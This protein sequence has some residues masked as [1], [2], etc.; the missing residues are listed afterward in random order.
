MAGSVQNAWRAQCPIGCGAL[1]S[2][3]DLLCLYVHLPFFVVFGSAYT[4]RPV[5]F[6]LRHF[7]LFLWLTG[8][9]WWACWPLSWGTTFRHWFA[10]DAL[11]VMHGY[12]CHSVLHS[13]TYLLCFVCVCVCVCV[14][15]V[16]SQHLRKQDLIY[17]WGNFPPS[18]LPLL[19]KF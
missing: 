3:T 13:D 5:S 1:H 17:W 18:I 14:L 2:S 10:K 8:K 6:L 15:G 12:H 19:Q 9:A 4:F 7:P 16:D 11:L